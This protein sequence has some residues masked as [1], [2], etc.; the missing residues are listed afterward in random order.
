MVLEYGMGAT[1][2][3]ATFPRQHRPGLLGQPT[4]VW[5]EGSRE[6]SEATAQAL[7][8]ETKQMLDE[9]MAH[10][11]ALLEGHRHQLERIAD[12]L[13][14]QEVLERDAFER[15]VHEEAPDDTKELVGAAESEGAAQA[16]R[17]GRQAAWR[18]VVVRA[19]KA[20]CF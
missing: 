20:C 3:P 1:L 19:W 12:V 16:E 5:P 9:R 2:G 6:Y 4:S 15:L 18:A 11:S 10:V 13:L 14:A 8:E 17:C 7:D